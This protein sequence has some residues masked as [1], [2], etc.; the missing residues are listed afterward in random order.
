MYIT[1]GGTCPSARVGCLQQRRLYHES[2]S[3][4]G[5]DEQIIGLV[6]V[7]QARTEGL[8]IGERHQH[9]RRRWRVSTQRR[10]GGGVFPVGGVRTQRGSGRAPNEEVSGLVRGN[11][12]NN[13]STHGRFCPEVP[14]H[15]ISASGGGGGG[16]RPRGAQ[17]Q[18]GAAPGILIKRLLVWIKEIAPKLKQ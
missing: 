1:L 5:P 12:A 10:N 3:L 18:R 11:L 6:Y 8:T 17:G 14:G 2:L 16:F 4:N 7:N 13:W 15:Y 9:R